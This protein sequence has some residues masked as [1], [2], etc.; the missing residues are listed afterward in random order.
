M[1]YSGEG[2]VWSIAGTEISQA[3]QK[4]RGMLGFFSVACESSALD[5]PSKF[6]AEGRST[7]L[8]SML[9]LRLKQGGE[10]VK[11]RADAQKLMK[12]ME[13][14]KVDC[15]PLPQQRAKQAVS[16]KLG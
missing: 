15:H 10:K 9:V 6:I 14:G 1:T 13:V 7:L 12:E 3:L 4:H 5:E 8:S 16:M 2:V 11:L